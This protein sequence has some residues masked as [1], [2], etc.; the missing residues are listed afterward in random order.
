MHIDSHECTCIEG[1]GHAIDD[2]YPGHPIDSFV[3]AILPHH[4][5]TLTALRT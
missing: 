1:W 4:F 2:R 3:I 5:S